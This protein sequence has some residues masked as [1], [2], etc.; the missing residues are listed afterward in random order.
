MGAIIEAAGGRQRLYIGEKLLN[1]L[2]C[3]RELQLS[4]S[5]TV[6]NDTS[7]GQPVQRAVC[8]GMTALAIGTAAILTRKEL[9]AG[10]LGV[11]TFRIQGDRI[12]K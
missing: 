5:W 7:L 12:S 1:T 9:S 4:H 2:F 11:C 3:C 6:Q 8:G 10:L